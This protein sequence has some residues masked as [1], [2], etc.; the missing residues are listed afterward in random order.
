MICAQGLPES[1]ARFP[2]KS[3]ERIK[4]KIEGTLVKNPYR[5]HNTA[6]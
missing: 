6:N 2:G 4:N 1:L 5:W 3:Q